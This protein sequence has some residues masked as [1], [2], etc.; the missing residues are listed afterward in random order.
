MIHLFDPAAATALHSLRERD[1][2]LAFDF[3]GTLAPIVREPELARMSPVTERLFARLCRVAACAVVSGRARADVTCRLGTAAPLYVVGNH[4]SEGD[5]A[6][7]ARDGVLVQVR[8]FLERELQGLVGVVVED[9][10]HTLSIHYR[11]AHDRTAALGDIERVLVRITQPL[12][13]QDG[14]AVINLLPANA[15]H[16]GDAL[17]ALCER[18]GAKHALFVGDDVTDEDAFGLTGELGLV[19]VRI[20]R[21]ANSSAKYYL[22][23]QAEI[24]RFLESLLSMRANHA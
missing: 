23:E 5:D 21:C 8:E 18:H 2:L 22:T 4:G 6:P 11:N 17:L 20:G 3:D 16:K 9:K 24:D 15:P 14:K 10:R 1:T 13:R 12:R 19:T 7:E